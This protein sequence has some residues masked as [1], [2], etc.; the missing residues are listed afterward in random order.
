[1]KTLNGIEFNAEPQ[2]AA[3]AQVD[4]PNARGSIAPH[5]PPIR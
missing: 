4:W 3:D 2:Q 1:M 5:P